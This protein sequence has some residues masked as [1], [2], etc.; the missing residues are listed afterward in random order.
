MDKST[1][2][3]QF[4]PQGRTV[5]W[6]VGTLALLAALCLT[7]LTVAD[8]PSVSIKKEAEPGATVP[9]E[10]IEYTVVFTNDEDVEISL[11]VI[12][13]SLPANFTFQTMLAGSDIT[14]D[15]TGTTGDIHWTGPYAI[16]AH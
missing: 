3:Q 10:S 14:D 8:E 5:P 2:P 11:M 9:D 1:L 4:L 16:A 7:V 13:D 6:L 15:P 12:S